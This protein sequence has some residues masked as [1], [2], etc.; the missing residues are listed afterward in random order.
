[1]Y[2]DAHAHTTHIHAATNIVSKAQEH[3]AAT[4]ILVAHD[5]S[6]L[7]RTMRPLA[8]SAVCQRPVAAAVATRR[9]L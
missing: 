8:C 9:P 4:A 6:E 2:T 5:Y 1:M 3:T 7:A